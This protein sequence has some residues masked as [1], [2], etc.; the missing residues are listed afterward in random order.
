M[1]TPHSP[2]PPPISSLPS[3]PQSHSPGNPAP[4]PPSFQPLATQ[5]LLLPPPIP[6]SFPSIAKPSQASMEKPYARGHPLQGAY[7]AYMF[8]T[9]TLTAHGC[10][11]GAQ[12]MELKW[13]LS[14]F[15]CG[16]SCS[17]CIVHM[18]NVHS[19]ARLFSRQPAVWP[20]VW[21]TRDPRRQ[22]MPSNGLNYPLPVYGAVV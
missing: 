5:W 7:S 11:H 4:P 1:Q 6:A 15:L 16:D 17:E 2:Q 21:P 13:L 22:F 12:D 9:K 20:E 3:F 18:K 8:Q 10:N 19:R 14:W